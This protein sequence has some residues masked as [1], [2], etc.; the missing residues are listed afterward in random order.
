MSEGESR[1]EHFPL[2][3]RLHTDVLSDKYGPIHAKVLRHDDEIRESHLEDKSGISRTY[4]LTFFP[5]KQD[6]SRIRKVDSEIR[7]GG[8]VGEVFRSHGFSI[9]KNVIGVRTVKMPEHLREAFSVARGHAKARLSEFY[10]KREGEPPV[11][12]GRVVEIYTPDFR[13]AAIVEEDI[14]QVNPTTEA[15][16]SAGIT[17]EDIWERLGR[18]NDWKDIEEKYAKAREIS[19]DQVHDLDSRI[20]SYLFR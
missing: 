11:I 4:A 20:D 8:L 14:A 17:K 3:D 13:P 12:Y 15:F 9:R 10:A 7:Q 1:G 5:R 16:E 6:D 19:L 18:N 2:V